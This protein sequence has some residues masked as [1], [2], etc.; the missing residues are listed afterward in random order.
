MLLSFSVAQAQDD[1]KK[2]DKN[3]KKEDKDRKDWEKDKKDEN[4]KDNV[5]KKDKN[6]K[7]DKKNKKD[8][9]DKYKED[10]RRSSDIINLPRLPNPFPRTT[11][12]KFTKVPPG[13]YPPPGEC[14]IWYPNRPPGHQPPSQSCSSLI[15]VRLT[16]GAFILHG[17]RAYDTEYD[18]REEAKR[19]PGTV[20]EEILDI[21]FP[22]RRR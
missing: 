8:K 17:D 6:Y 12:R 11:P 14:R 20:A 21:L 19:R 4:E 15:G 9:K 1:G 18:W 7:K 16:D 5:W 2:W 22:N 13:H 3:Q 10:E